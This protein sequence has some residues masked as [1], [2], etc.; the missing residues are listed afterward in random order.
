M[1]A[2][3]GEGVE[4]SDVNHD[5]LRLFSKVL[6]TFRVHIFGEQFFSLR[7]A[8]LIVG[9]LPPVRPP[10]VHNPAMVLQHRPRFCHRPC[11]CNGRIAV[12]R[13]HRV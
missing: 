12:Q 7:S 13:P 4:L 1:N 6:G 2:R 3:D 9:E 11:G 8:C 10:L 5:K